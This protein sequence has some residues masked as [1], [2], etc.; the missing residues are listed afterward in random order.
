MLATAL[1]VACVAATSTATPADVVV[2]VNATAPSGT[3]AMRLGTQFVWPGGLDR[4]NGTR[5]R[6]VALAPPLVRINAAPIGDPPVLPAGARQGDWNFEALDSI[7]NDIRRADA[8]VL[9]T[10]L[11]PPEWIWTCATGP[12]RDPDFGDFGDYMARLVAYYNTGAFVAENGHTI[13]NPAGVANRIGYWELW[14]E[15][16]QSKGCPPGGNHLGPRQYVAMWNGTAP[17][18]LAIDPTIKLIGPATSNSDTTEFPDYIPALLA[19][20]T[21]KPD[22]ISFHAYGGGLNSQSD[23]FHFDGEG[24]GAG[25]EGIERGLKRVKALARDIPVWITEMNVNAVGWN[26]GADDER[27]WTEFSA[28][29]GASAFRRLALAGADMVLQYQFAHP[30]FRRFSL[31]DVRT[32]EPLLPYWRD[33][34]LARYFP[35]GST[36][37]SSGSNLAGIESLAVRPPGS[38][39]LHVLVINRQ[40]GED[41]L[42]GR[43]RP[44]T[45]RVDVR[46]WSGGATI[47]ARL[48]DST[49]PLDTGPPDV[50]L[51][52]DRSI[53]VAFPGYGAAFVKIVASR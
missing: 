3:I 43:G 4:A 11:M 24:S 41:P 53:S 47:T 14:N 31:V 34:Y 27:S 44:T 8:E 37:I 33:Y 26:D 46:N 52:S 7:V 9:L 18:M 30:Y 21:H 15:P 40:I 2:T 35:P 48:I 25:L 17:K 6:F 39:E 36:V 23:R 5:E 10:A 32:G 29:W 38:D 51:P 19:G 28:A 1:V 45:I 20:A 42:G 16:D 12:V 22:A 50:T 49:T 13:T